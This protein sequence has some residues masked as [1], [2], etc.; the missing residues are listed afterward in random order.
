MAESGVKRSEIFYTTKLKVNDTVA[1][2]TA[3]IDRSL[4][5]AG[6]DYL[7]LYLIHGSAVQWSQLT[8]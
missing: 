2:A 7:D 4:R 5:L 1:S 6:L 3:A 8:R